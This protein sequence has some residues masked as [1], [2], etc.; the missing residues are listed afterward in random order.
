MERQGLDRLS[1]ADAANLMLESPTQAYT[2]MLIGLLEPGGLLDAAGRPDLERLRAV[3]APRVDRIPRLRQVVR[4]T[5]WGEGRPIWVETEVRLGRHVRAVPPVTGRAG[6]TELCGDLLSRP[7]PRDRPL[8]DLL[9][10]PGVE[11]DRLGLVLRLHHA[12]ADGLRAMAIV[13]ELFD[14][15][16]PVDAAAPD[17]AAAPV[18]AAAP[19]VIPPPSSRA[20]RLDAMHHRLGTM[21]SGLRGL[22]GLPA[23]LPGAARGVRRA[24]GI[25]TTRI[26][27]T[28]LLGPLRERRTVSLLDADLEGLR[29]C[30][31]AHGGTVNDVLLAAVSDGVRAL[32][33]AR[34][35]AL[36]AVLPISVP[37][38][39][40][41]GPGTNGGDPPA[42][43]NAVG[44]MLVRVPL[45]EPDLRRR[46]R[47]IAAATRA[48]R[49]RA[50]AAGTFELTRWRWVARVSGRLY[51]RQRVVA[52]FVTDLVGPQQPLTLAGA[53][54]TD[55]WPVSVIAGN[56]RIGVAA[57]S[58]AGRVRFGVVSDSAS[59]PDVDLFTTALSDAL[60]RLTEE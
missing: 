58:Y 50:R 23:A 33:G 17:V 5:R 2:M 1:A 30:G 8:W 20:L 41:G 52:L 21:R 45:A 13:G 51:A 3:L 12:V 39:V 35:E 11:A 60:G 59:T 34:G 6:F 24:A 48:E 40:R 36:P 16:A 7:L 28:S 32:L 56:V 29:R 44:V 19:A 15:A 47:L 54:F 10:V 37:V 46:L 9:V 38:S 55:A 26:P 43:G 4:P 53:R 18:D 27:P 25:L 42:E 49:P 14:A 22:P 57:L 31:H